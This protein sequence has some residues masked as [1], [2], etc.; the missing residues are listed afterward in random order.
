VIPLS[1]P[2]LSGNERQYLE[3]CLQSTFVSSVGAFVPRF[4]EAFARNIGSPHTVACASGT[5]A[6]HVALH[7]A[8]VEPGDD[9]L[10]SD[11]TFV[12]TA[13]PIVY[14]GA[15]PVFVDAD[16]AT[17]NIDPILVVEE[18]E[19]RAAAGIR[20]PKAVLAA[21]VLGLPA[22]L[23]PIEDAC[24]RHGVLLLEDA[25]EALGASYASGPLKDR[26][27]GTIGLLGCFSF[28]GNKIITTGGGGMIASRD[29]LL[30]RRARHLTTQ[31]KIPGPEYLHD[32]V[33]YNY[34]L[35]NLAAALGLA[36]LE[37]LPEFV[38]RKREIA[39]RYDTALR[40]LPG[41]TIP[42]RPAWALPTL[43]LYSVL[44]DPDVAGVDRKEVLK[45]LEAM[46]IQTRP[47]WAPSHLMSFYKD[48][49]RLGGAVGERLFRHGLSLPCSTSLTCADQERVI[50]GL[51]DI[52]RARH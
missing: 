34:R 5:A 31:A 2:N 36:Q 43:W 41:V 48:A 8:G 47:I 9:V 37:R 20:Q 10:V 52:W 29:E 40:D 14:R 44:I 23:G 49:P 17:W 6:L 38:K 18:L 4:E 42:P 13:N 32:E 15:R 21:H 46:S 28:N 45:Q 12:A 24:V 19:R 11:F 50:E 1:V 25:A 39:D 16:N 51:T 30:T 35:T 22:D 33:G 27:A 26:Q 3:E 7:V